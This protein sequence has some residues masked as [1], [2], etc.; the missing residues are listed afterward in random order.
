[1]RQATVIMTLSLVKDSSD[2]LDAVLTRMIE[3]ITDKAPNLYTIEDDRI[4][5]LM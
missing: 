1:M 5:T 4:D 3:E 2:G